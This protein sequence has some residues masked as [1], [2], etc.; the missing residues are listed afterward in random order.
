MKLV[1]AGELSISWLDAPVMIRAARL[2]MTFQQLSSE[3]GVSMTMLRSLDQAL[4]SA[5][6]EPSDRIKAA[7]E[8]CIS[9]RRSW[10]PEPGRTDAAATPGGWTACAASLRPKPNSSKPRSRNRFGAL[11]GVSASCSISGLASEVASTLNWSARSQTSTAGT[12]STSGIQHSINHA[13]VA[14]ERAGLFE[15]VAKPPAILPPVDL[16]GYTRLTEGTRRRVRRRT[17]GEARI[18]RRGHLS[19]PWRTTDPLARDAGRFISRSPPPPFSRALT[20]SRALQ[21]RSLP[22]DAYRHP[23]RTR[24]LPG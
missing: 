2:D 7:T 5:P 17:R 1:K 4:G 3:E 6:P 23:H 14:L 10:M 16:T 19:S 15:K 8:L 9:F 20:W 24:H 22:P 11:G 18:P 12:E 21:M 13:E